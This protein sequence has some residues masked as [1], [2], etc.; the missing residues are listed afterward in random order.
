MRHATFT[1][2]TAWY[3]SSL[4][5]LSSQPSSAL[6]TDMPKCAACLSTV[7]EIDQA[8]GQTYCAGCGIVLEENTIVSEVTFGESSSGA[9]VLQGSYVGADAVRARVQGPGGQRGGGSQESRENT[10]YNGRIRIKQVAQGLKLS[11]RISDAAIRWFNLAVSTN[12]TK[13]RKTGHVVAC[14]LYVTCRMQ[15]THHMLIDFSDLLQVNVFNLGAVYLRLVKALN[16]HLPVMDPSLYISRFASLLEFGDETQKVAT[17]AVRLV[18]RFKRDWMDTGRRPAGICGACLL[19]AARMNNFRRSVEEIVQVVKIAD[20]T[21][22]KRLEEFQGTASSELTIEAFRTTWLE[23]GADPPA[24]TKGL[25]KKKA[26]L[27]SADGETEDGSEFGDSDDKRLIRETSLMPPP[28]TTNGAGHSSNGSG[29]GKGVAEGERGG[30]SSVTPVPS[31]FSRQSSETPSA[32]SQF[33][34]SLSNYPSP[35][36][37]PSFTHLESLPLDSNKTDDPWTPGGEDIPS[38]PGSSIGGFDKTDE[39]FDPIIAHEVTS[40]LDSNQGIQLTTELNESERKAAERRAAE[41]GEL[42]LDGLDDDELDQFILTDEEATI[43]T[44]LWVE[45]NKDY[46]EKLA[47]K[48]SKV[49]TDAAGSTVRKPRKKKIPGSERGATAADS[50]KNLV[51]RKFSRKINYKAFDALFDNEDLPQRMSERQ[52]RESEQPMEI[53][54]VLGVNDGGKVYEVDKTDQPGDIVFESV[55]EE[56]DDPKQNGPKRIRPDV[57]DDE[58]DGGDDHARVK[59]KTQLASDGAG[60]GEEDEFR[61]FNMYGH[62]DEED[63]FEEV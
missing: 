3:C 8:Q 24:Y 39:T 61:S 28:L 62:G 17:D 21:L 58:S 47:L 14:C 16:L 27:L 36:P 10:L 53:E 31:S 7:V 23:E 4:S 9:A 55:F 19:L 20:T 33:L 57:S 43:K 15:K 29:K 13:G 6:A 59:R 40:Y 5:L 63:G 11:E 35:S 54:A 30:R 56:V 38:T 26:H 51:Q 42:D 48:E 18:Q 41:S 12:F 60:G 2:R 25:K 32:T 45:F 22:R 37:A 46:L 49:L 50:A 44:R 52:L 1:I 34:P